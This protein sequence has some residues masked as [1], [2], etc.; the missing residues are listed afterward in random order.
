MSLIQKKLV[1]VAQLL[2]LDQVSKASRLLKSIQIKKL[3]PYQRGEFFFHQAQIHQLQGNFPLALKNFLVSYRFYKSQKSLHYQSLIAHHL[4]DIYR[5]IESFDLAI[6][7][8]EE[9][10]KLLKNIP[11]NNSSLIDDAITGRAL[12][13]RG[14]GK[15]QAAI[16]LLLKQKVRYEKA[17]DY[18]AAAYANWAIGTTYRFI[19]DF[20]KAVNHLKKS[21]QIYSRIQDQTGKAYAFCGLGGTLRMMGVPTESL[22]CY[23][24]AH[25]TFKSYGDQF[26]QAYS[27]CGTGNAYRMMRN[28]STAI[29]FSHQ[30]E[31]LYRKLKQ[32]GP[33]G[34]VLW[35]LAQNEIALGL[36]KQAKLHLIEAWKLFKNVNDQRGLTYVQLGWGEFFRDENPAKAKKHYLLAG[37]QA[38]K[39][40]ILFEQIHARARIHLLSGGRPLSLNLD[41]PQYKK[42]GVDFESFRKYETLP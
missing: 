24:F 2:E 10:Q 39:C 14:K 4:G 33:L 32:K 41:F 20:K 25:K 28:Y 37:K 7:W 11:K 5:Q 26:G 13:F 3:L 9:V 17:K 36:K 18:E 27:L 16:N 42:C 15:Y 22:E 8:Y 30:A 40:G 29:K 12:S 31:Q 34:F 1:H 23:L 6:H 35:S 21:L 19:G 38:K